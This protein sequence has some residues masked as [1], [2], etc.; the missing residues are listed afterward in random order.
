MT[1]PAWQ[2]ALRFGLEVGS[3][4]AVGAWA[5]QLTAGAPNLL[6]AIGASLLLAV[7]WGSFAVKG[8]PSRSGNA[9]VPVPGVLRLAIEL[10]VF[11]AGAASLAT[12]GQWVWF[13]VFVAALLVHHLGTTERISWLLK[14]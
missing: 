3:L 7:L 2:L 6:A 10:I 12:R 13:G 11:G 14:Q 8:D 9:P 4:V 5:Y 1:I